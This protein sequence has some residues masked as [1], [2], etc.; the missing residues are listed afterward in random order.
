MAWAQAW[1]SFVVDPPRL[2]QVPNGL[3][4]RNLGA[5]VAAFSA[6]A[7][8][9]SGWLLLGLPGAVYLSG[10]SELWIGVGVV[11]GAFLNWR[12]YPRAYD[13]PRPRRAVP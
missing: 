11:V 9:M 7:S 3:G 5:G 1:R 4:G 12:F 13:G 6:G 2:G 10:L 8:D